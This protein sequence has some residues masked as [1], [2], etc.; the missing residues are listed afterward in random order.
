MPR[1]YFGWAMSSPGARLGP[2]IFGVAQ[3]EQLYF[4]QSPESPPATSP[5]Q[6][7]SS[8]TD[9]SMHFDSEDISLNAR[10]D[11]QPSLPVDSTAFTS[12]LDDLRMSILQRINDSNSDMFSKLNILEI[13]FRET[14]RQHEESLK[15]SI[16]N[17]RQDSRYLDDIQTLRLNEFRK[18]VLTQNASVF[19]GLADVR[20]EV[21]ELNA[22]V[23]I[24]ATKLEIVKKDVEATK[25]YI[26]HQLLEFQTQEQANHIVLTDHLGQLVDYINRGG[27]A[28]K[29]EGESSRG[30][31]PPPAVQIRDSSISGGNVVR[32]TELGNVVRTT[33]LTQADIDA[34]NRQILERMM[35]EDRE[36]E[37]EKRSRSGSYKRRRY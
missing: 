1:S 13:G 19:T 31:Q 6:E 3:E 11:I 4:V 2:V 29:G 28:K 12:A 32:T 25:E 18:N 20:K 17:V 7:S 14:L 9:V 21:Q 30:P 22:K 34:A 26:S 16:Q 27:N 8:S 15:Q 36:R 35:R 24:M 10:A 33:E 23:D 5:H 37:K